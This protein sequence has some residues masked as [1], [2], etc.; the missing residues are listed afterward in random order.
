[1]TVESQVIKAP[2]ELLRVSKEVSL[3][4]DVFNTISQKFLTIELYDH[5]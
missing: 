5:M 3:H 1:M 4:E 2:D